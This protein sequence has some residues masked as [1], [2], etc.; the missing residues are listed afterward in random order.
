M[1]FDLTQF[2]AALDA[3]YVHDDDPAALVFDNYLRWKGTPTF[4]VRPVFKDDAPPAETCVSPHFTVLVYRANPLYTT[5]CTLGASCRIIP[6]SRAS[7]GDER[8]VRY[9]Y[10]IHAAPS[11]EQHAAQ[12]LALIAEYPFI[13]T[14]EIGPGY[15]LPVGEPVVPGSPMEYLYFTYPYLDDGRLYESNPWGQIERPDLLIQM[16]WV[17]PIYRSEA[18][19]IRAK[20]IEAFEQRLQ[21]RHSRIYDA[22]DMLRLPVVEH[23]L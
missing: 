9:E 17:L 12:L 6:F 23:T 16:L 13:H 11:N 14:I 4:L 10:I 22:Y 19:F 8:G 5:L 15:I 18:Q 2:R 3:A 20:G 1:T 21:E 7:F